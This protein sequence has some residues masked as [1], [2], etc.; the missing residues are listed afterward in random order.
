[1]MLNNGDVLTAVC[2]MCGISQVLH[3]LSLLHHERR[4]N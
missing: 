2:I 1:M 4:S 3:R